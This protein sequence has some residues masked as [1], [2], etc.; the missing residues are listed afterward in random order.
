MREVRLPHS[1][2]FNNMTNYTQSPGAFRYAQENADHQSHMSHEAESSHENYT[3]TPGS[4]AADLA[5]SPW[6]MDVPNFTSPLSRTSSLSSSEYVS[7]PPAY[8]E[9]TSMFHLMDQALPH[10]SNYMARGSQYV[11]DHELGWQPHVSG[12]DVCRSQQHL[13][14]HPV[15]SWQPYGYVAPSLPTNLDYIASPYMS[16][17]PS[18]APQVVLAYHCKPE[19]ADATVKPSDVS[20]PSSSN[21]DSDSDDSAYE[22]STS[23]SGQRRGSRSNSGPNH[24]KPHVIK[25]GPW[26]NIMDP[27]SHPPARHYACPRVDLG[28]VR[29]F[30]RPEHLRRHINTVHGDKRDHRCKVPKCATK[31]FSRSDN[32]RDHYWSHLERGGRTGKNDKM[33][34]SELKEILGP[35]ERKLIKK[36]K[37]RLAETLSKQRSTRQRPQF[38]SKL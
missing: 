22:E 38:R 25:L 12:G 15:S 37:L 31:P 23:S 1:N 5:F 32:L 2:F 4:A 29:R 18:S 9:S 11:N 35:K 21:S 3:H 27:Y 34:L 28:C 20:T 19:S 36:L 17:V 16:N 14:H 13:P 7:T 8:P 6:L 10:S 33:S 24:S 26:H 30:A